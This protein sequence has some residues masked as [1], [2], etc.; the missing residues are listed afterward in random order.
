M[1]L[2]LPGSLS[3][4]CHVYA[5]GIKLTGLVNTPIQHACTKAKVIDL[6]VLRNILEYFCHFSDYVVVSLVSVVAL[7]VWVFVLGP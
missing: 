7:I 1:A 3:R 5:L 2:S 4:F 6:F